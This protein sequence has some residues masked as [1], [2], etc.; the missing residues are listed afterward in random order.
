MHSYWYKIHFTRINKGLSIVLDL[1]FNKINK[2]II[3]LYAGYVVALMTSLVAMELIQYLIMVLII[4]VAVYNKVVLRTN[5][6]ENNTLNKLSLALII[7]FMF[8]IL[9]SP[10]LMD[11]EVSI[12]KSI[13]KFSV[14]LM[15]PFNYLLLKRYFPYKKAF[16]ISF[17]VLLIISTYA[18]FQMFTGFNPRLG[19]DS[20]KFGVSNYV[21]GLYSNYIYYSN[22][23]QL[24][25][26]V[27]LGLILSKA[28]NGKTKVFLYFISF[29]LLVTIIFAGSR[30]AFGAIFFG[31]FVM[32][33]ISKNI[34]LFALL[35]FSLGIFYFSYKYNH[36]LNHKLNYTIKKIN[37]IG[38]E[39]RLENWKAHI[40]IFKNNPVKGVGLWI[41]VMKMKDYFDKKG[42]NPKKFY[43]GHSHNNYLY[44]LSSGGILGFIVFY[45]LWGYIF[46][47]LVKSYKIYRKRSQNYESGIAI[48]LI[49]AFS[50]LMINSITEC[51]SFVYIINNNISFFVA[52]AYILYEN[53][54]KSEE[55]H[56]I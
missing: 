27:I 14:F 28:F 41:N 19:V 32:L 48:G 30:V 39:K 8:S 40:D 11:E 36:H 49:A 26:F 20:I 43:V 34:K 2:L 17:Y 35:I 50:S 9:S 13:Q 12:V 51:T 31:L 47:V 33:A 24:Y 18:V 56:K 55:T 21:T 6:F 5:L 54:N 29:A 22:V 46:Y 53:T 44:V 52:V 7:I 25:F 37:I 42:M 23:F 1:T 10:Y 16:K 4:L 45:F 15:I 38:D 3:Y